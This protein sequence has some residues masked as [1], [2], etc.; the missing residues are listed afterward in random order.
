MKKL[1]IL[2]ALFLFS[3]EKETPQPIEPICDC[4]VVEEIEYMGL[5]GF[6]Y[7][8]T[9]VP[10]GF[11][12]ETDCDKDGEVIQTWSVQQWDGV[13]NFRKRLICE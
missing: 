4:K 6:W 1:T 8:N 11:S 7:R 5:S 12:I 10:Y 13:Q 9:N 3:C 2:L